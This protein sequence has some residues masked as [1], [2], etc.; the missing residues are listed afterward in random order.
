M[1]TVS[2]FLAIGALVRGA[3]AENHSVGAF[4]FGDWHPNAQ[5]EAFHGDGWTEFALVTNATPRFPDHVQPNVPV[6]WPVNSTNREDTLSGMQQRIE[7]AS[8]SGLEFFMFDWYWYAELGN[9]SDGGVF[10]DGALESGFLPALKHMA[11]V[12]SPASGFQFSLMWANQDWVD[13]HPAKAG[14]HGTGRK[15]NATIPRDVLLMFDG[16]MSPTVYSSAFDYIIANYMVHPNYKRL[17]TAG[18]GGKDCAWFSFYLVEY[19]AQGVGGWQQAATA[20]AD[21]RARAA[22]EPSVGCLHLTGMDLEAYS[23]AQISQL[24]LDSASHYG[25]MK[26]VVGQFPET[27]YTEV[28][29]QAMAKWPAFET[30]WGVPFIPSASV[31]WDPSPRCTVTDSYVDRGYPWSPTWRSTPAQ[32][33]TALEGAR[34]YLDKRCAAA[35]MPGDERARAQNATA[36]LCPP[37]IINAW[38]EWSEGAYLE[39]DVREGTARLDAV[40]AAFA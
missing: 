4:Y 8:S 39:P 11:A 29:Q 22:A 38:N 21:F 3:S 24:G 12:N 36:A 15:S 14:F 40:K 26:T 2:V 31:A 35:G 25:W 7:L 20:L 6:W 28:S 33:Q 10:L 19:L 37:L 5:M 27:P 30:Q 13:V 32:F 17:P 16:F 1:L 34:S 9:T 18:S 23:P